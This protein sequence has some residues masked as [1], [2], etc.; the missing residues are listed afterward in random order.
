MK[1]TYVYQIGD[2]LYLNLTNR[3]SNFCTFCV[4]NDKESYEGYP[5]WLKNGEPTIEQVIEEI[6]DPKRYKEVVFCGFGEPTFRIDAIVEIAEYV[7]R[8]GGK[9]R[10]NTNGLGSYLNGTDIVPLLK[11]RIDAVNVSLNAPTKKEYDKVCRPRIDESFGC[12]V[13]FAQH[14]HEAGLNTWF[15]VVDCIGEEAI[16]GC[17][18]IAEAIGIPLR[19]R[20]TIK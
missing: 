16:A 14:C 11:G 7:H 19:V 15:S 2:N 20:K 10:L 9:T 4:R 6:G 17:R 18:R 12:M 1:D 8:K 3:C 13:S 5:L